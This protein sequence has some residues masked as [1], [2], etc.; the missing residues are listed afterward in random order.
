MFEGG[1][2]N[3]AAGAGLTV[4]VLVVLIVL[5]QTSVAVQ[6]SVTVPPHGPGATDCVDVTVPLIK[7]LPLAPL[8]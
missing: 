5:P 8:E 6:V 7:Q 3:V 2:I 1:D 4:I